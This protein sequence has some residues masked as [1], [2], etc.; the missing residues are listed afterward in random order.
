MS[1]IF[2]TKVVVTTRIGDV[3]SNIHYP[4]FKSFDEFIDVDHLRS[5]NSYIANKIKRRIQETSDSFFL[6]QHRLDESSAY[7]PGAREIWLTRTLP[8]IPYN[9]LDLDRTDLWEPTDEAIEFTLLM[10]FVKKLPFKALGRILIIYDELGREVPA[11]RDHER[12]DICNEF[13]W[14]RTNLNKPFYLLNDRTG[15]K[16]YVNSYSAWFDTVNQFHGCDQFNGL[17]FSIRVDG[18]FT[19]EFRS[20]IP[21][22]E[23]NAASTPSLWSCV[24]GGMRAAN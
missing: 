19:D 9:Y 16:L 22:P 17:S 13:I 12:V 10:E 23:Y 1:A 8:G 4:S 21:K 20:R 11:H 6:N 15:E 3:Q 7:A 18:I 24:N 2:E 5:L 14:L